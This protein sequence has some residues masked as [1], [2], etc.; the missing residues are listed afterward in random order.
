M[1]N[2]NLAVKLK[3]KQ[4]LAIMPHALEKFL[5]SVYEVN[6]D[7]SMRKALTKLAYSPKTEERFAIAE[8]MA[9]DD[10]HMT[11]LKMFGNSRAPYVTA[12][13]SGVICI[14]GVI[15]KGLNMMEKMIGCTDIDDIQC[16]L[17]CWKK[18]P[19]VQRVIFKVNSGGGTTT[20]LEETARMIFDYPKETFTFTDDDMGSAALWLGSQSKRVL[21]TPS[22][23][24][25]S[26]GIYVSITDESEKFKED[27]KEVILIKAGKYKGAGVDGVPLTKDQGDYIQ[28]EV[29]ELWDRFKRDLTR[30]RPFIKDEDMEGQ[31]FYGDIAANKGFVTGLVDSW[32]EALAEIEG[33]PEDEINDLLAGPRTEPVLQKGVRPLKNQPTRGPNRVVVTRQ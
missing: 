15:G 5:T 3:S 31:S 28:D 18:D 4:P 20:G 13:G 33:T 7:S 9:D 30:A 6:A 16:Q 22:S 1:L 11:A 2:S 12:K 24:V 32:E 29:F 14:S 17:R 23:S 27:G 25:G 8:T 19:S 26:V 10:D 21:A